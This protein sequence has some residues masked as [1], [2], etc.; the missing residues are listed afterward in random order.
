MNLLRNILSIT[1]SL[2]SCLK[3]REGKTST[4]CD[5]ETNSAS[6][7][8]AP[9][10]LECPVIAPVIKRDQHVD[11]CVQPPVPDPARCLDPISLVPLDDGAVTQVECNHA[12]YS[13]VPL[14]SYLIRSHPLWCDPLSSE[15]VS[16]AVIL[17]IDE[18]L[19]KMKRS[20]DNLEM[21]EE[22][23][24]LIQSIPML[25]PLY[26]ARNDAIQQTEALKLRQNEEVKRSFTS[27]MDALISEVYN[28]LEKDAQD[29]EESKEESTNGSFDISVVSIFSEFETIF[30]QLAQEDLEYAHNCLEGYKTFLLGPAKR[31]TK[32]PKGRL[33]GLL[34]L[35]EGLI[36]VEQKEEVQEGRR[37]LNSCDL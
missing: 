21:T 36:T 37:R 15:E 25:L 3:F 28:T 8:T 34:S 29:D 32:D 35:L 9:T 6:E 17:E 18:K 11:F 26:E 20:A 13:L 14:A 33:P 1:Q 24:V 4:D 12:R 16:R 27:I 23:S 31:P 22:E 2:F 5:I 19:G 7:P 10:S 30:K